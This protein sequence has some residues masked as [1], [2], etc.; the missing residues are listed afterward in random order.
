MF[1]CYTMMR[2]TASF[3][4]TDVIFCKQ[5]MLNW[6]ARFGICC[7]MDSCNYKDAYSRFDCIAAA[8]AEAVCLPQHN[9]LQQLKIFTQT[10]ADWLFGHIGY[11]LKNEIE[12]LS[13]RHH[14][15][16]LFPDLFFFQPQVVMY[17]QGNIL[18][19]ESLHEKPEIVYK[20]VIETKVD[21]FVFTQNKIQLQSRIDKEIYIGIIGQLQQHILRGDCYE[22][23]FCQEFFSEETTI[24]PIEVYMQLSHFSSA[25]FSA[26]YKLNDKYAFCASPERFLQKKNTRLISQP[27]KGTLKRN[28]DDVIDDN[29]LKQQL[30]NSVKNKIENVMITDLVR[31]DL[32]KIC[33]RGSV[34]VTELFGVYSYP[35]VHQ[36]ITTVEG[37]T[38]ETINFADAL[39][40][41]FPMGSM[42]GAPKRRVMQ[43]TEQYEHSKRGLYSG[44][45]GYITPQNDWDFNVVIRSILYNETNRYLSFQTGG[46]IT[47]GSDAEE[48]YEECLLKAEAMRKALGM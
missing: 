6:A 38:E 41:M 48:E 37:E 39:K 34:D 45:L 30:K 2:N 13:S 22:I 10:S 15:K 44:S 24:N 29:A 27:I 9:K 11:D 31:N 23:N 3:A 35:Q 25:P 26:Y 18:T 5:Q 46:A 14:D 43:L 40:A 19:I 32:S 1:G 20:N 47:F 7:F 28:L 16:L 36:M 4:V 42:T 12:N 33:R 8:G 17:L 21:R